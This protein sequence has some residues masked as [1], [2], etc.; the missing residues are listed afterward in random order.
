MLLEKIK[1][2]GIIF[3]T[4]NNTAGFL[5]VAI[6]RDTEKKTITL[7]QT[8]LIDR[9]VEAIGLKYVQSIQ[10]PAEVTTLGK[11]P[12]GD[13]GNAMFNHLSIIEMM[14]YLSSHNRCSDK[15]AN[16]LKGPGTRAWSFQEELPIST[17][18]VMWT[19]TLQDCGVVSLPM[20]QTAPIVAQGLSSQ[21][22]TVLLFGQV[23]Y[24]RKS[25]AIL[26]RTNTSP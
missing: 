15:S 9:V 6:E 18:T 19:Q 5:G 20:I 1:Y 13:K 11:N 16:I 8:G 22:V 7:M 10:T 14:L 24:K 17:L 3:N 26:W 23:S 21:F 2:E 4:E 25:A 12:N